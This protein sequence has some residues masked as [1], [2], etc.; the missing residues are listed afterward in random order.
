MTSGNNGTCGAPICTAGTGW[1]GPTGLGTPNGTA[2]FT[3]GTS[4]PGPLALANPGNQTSGT[5]TAVSLTLSASGGTA[6]YT[7]SATGL[8]TGLSIN[9]STGVISGT[10][11]TVGTFSVV[12]TVHDA[13][14]GT[15]TASFTWTITTSTLHRHP[16]AR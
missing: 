6:P 13:A 5:G 7:F 14:S 4:A 10:P 15:A 12:A 1:D 11:T 9:T 3:N 8:P 2:A 16:A